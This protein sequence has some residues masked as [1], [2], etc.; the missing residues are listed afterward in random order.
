VDNL[1]TLKALLRGFE[2]ASGLKVNF[3]KSCLMGIN[4]PS[5]FMSMACDF[6]NCS[7]GAVP[8]KYLEL[9][10]GANSLKISTW[11]PLLEHI[12]RKLNSWGHKYVSLGGRIVLLNAVINAIPIFYLSFLKMPNKVWRR[13][14]KIQRDFLWGMAKGRK[15]A[16]LG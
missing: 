2:M 14:V 16:L 5:E 9:P 10:V 8:F 4:V 7:E 15:E 12:S 1:W 11:E 6:L 3:Y 13:L